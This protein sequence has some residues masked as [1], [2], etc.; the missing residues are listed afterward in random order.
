[1]SYR[2]WFHYNKPESTKAGKPKLTL[3]YRGTCH[4]LDK[5]ETQVPI[6]TKNNKTQ[7]RCV[8]RG[9]SKRLALVH[10]N[11]QNIGVLK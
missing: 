9:F 3:H 2:F 11:G 10:E 4:I 8:V 6:E 7:P 5:I 1:V